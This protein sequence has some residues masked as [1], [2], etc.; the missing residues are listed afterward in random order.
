MIKKH[1]VRQFNNIRSGFARYEFWASLAIFGFTVYS[2]FDELSTHAEMNQGFSRGVVY[3]VEHYLDDL[4]KVASIY[5]AYLFL[6]FY[7]VPRLIAGQ[8]HWLNIA[9]TIGTFLL[10]ALIYRQPDMAFA[11]M[12]LFAGYTAVRYGSIYLWMNAASLENKLSF[13]APGG[14]ITLILWGLGS[15]LLIVGEAESAA[16]AAWLLFIPVG[17][18]LYSYFFFSQIPKSRTRRRPLLN[19]YLWAILMLALATI[20]A[21]ILVLLIIED[22]DTAFSISMLNSF[23]HLIITVPFSWFFYK[24]Y[25]RGREE[26]TSLQKELGQSAATLDFLRSQINPHFLFNALNTLYGTAI[27]EKAERTGEGI[28]KLG[29]MMRFMLEE[30]NQEKISLGHEIEYLNNYI[31]LQKLRTD[32]NPSIAITNEFPEGDVRYSIAPMLL[33]PFVENAFKHGISFRQ[34]SHIRITLSLR[35]ATLYFDVWNSIHPRSEHDPEKN[36]NGIGLKNVKQRLELLYPRKHDLH[37]RET[38]KEF[39]VHLTIQLS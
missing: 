5:L 38:A 8:R 28:Q 3:L 12:G 27:Q 2:F 9:L 32:I 15:F 20:P 21:T 22:D 39:F 13:I 6:N 37:I 23:L 31:S 34:P 33:V 26:V 24:R 35:D 4:A 7:M 25:M 29:D 11:T 19:Y 17:V 30:N 16:L 14:V 10:L 1:I 36:S 18:M